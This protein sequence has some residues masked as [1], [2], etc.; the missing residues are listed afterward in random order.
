[1]KQITQFLFAVMLSFPIAMA[2]ADKE[3][4]RIEKEA[5]KTE[6]AWREEGWKLFGRQDTLRLALVSHHRKLQRLGESARELFGTAVAANKEQAASLHR[7]AELNAKALF[8]KERRSYIV[9]KAVTELG[10]SAGG[11][12]DFE[13]FVGETRLNAEGVVKRELTESFAKIRQT[14]GGKTEIVVY[15]IFDTS[16]ADPDIQALIRQY[17]ASGQE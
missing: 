9:S 10:L 5:R 12:D 4:K 6:K 1:M 3:E 7:R 15:Y 17:R 11:T 14:E 16:A 8:V 13:R 2:A